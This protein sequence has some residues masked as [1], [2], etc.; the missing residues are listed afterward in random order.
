MCEMMDAKSV[1]M[2]GAQMMIGVCGTPQRTAQFLS[3]LK[4]ISILE[5]ARCGTLA[6][7]KCE[8]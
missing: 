2:A 7:P 1:E 3:Q 5:V 6:L 4:G 8:N